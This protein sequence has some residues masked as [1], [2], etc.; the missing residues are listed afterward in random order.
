MTKYK[1]PENQIKDI[2]K[3]MENLYELIG[4]LNKTKLEDLNVDEITSKVNKFEKKYKDILPKD[5]KDNL[6]SKK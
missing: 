2:L 5:S 4:D 1:N 6:D 3:D